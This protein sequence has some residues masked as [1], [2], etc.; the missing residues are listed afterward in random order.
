MKS[1]K[2]KQLKIDIWIESGSDFQNEC[3][4]S[5]MTMTLKV[6]KMNHEARNKK[7]VFD[8]NMEGDLK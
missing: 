3:I 2:P 1:K 8:F 6:M 4:E 5:L 7:N